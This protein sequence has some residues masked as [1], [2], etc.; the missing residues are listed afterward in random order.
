M[1][2]QQLPFISQEQ[3]ADL[4]PYH[5]LVSAIREV[6]ASE[7]CIPERGHYDLNPETPGS[8]TLLTM[9]AWIPGE[10]LGVKLVNIVPGN[11][12]IPTINGVYVL[13]NAETGQPLCLM[14]APELTA[15]RTAAASAL[16]A[17]YLARKDARH[18]L[19]IGPGKLSRYLI[20]AHCQQAEIAQ[21]TIWGRN[22]EQITKLIHGLT[23]LDCPI[24]ACNDLPSAVATAD[25]ISC[26]TTAT[27]PIIKGQWL[28]PG[29]HLDLVGAFRPDMREVDDVAIQR[30]NL[31][32]DT[33]AAIKE[34]GEL[35]IPMQSGVITP[36]DIQADL[37]ALSRNTHPG[38]NNDQELTLFK[39]VGTAVEDLAAAQLAADYLKRK[40]NRP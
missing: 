20:E 32:V 30:C 39:S 8:A 31:F 27:L 24:N 18:L 9:P 25:I 10:A 2:D 21:V 28:Q 5:Q 36:Q 35:C 3:L 11:V 6:F 34:A 40:T 29:T 26:A 38:R 19:M 33:P 12:A 22:Q 37:S 14:D 1:N 4:L 23:H 7:V 16:A 17:S 15:R 13:F